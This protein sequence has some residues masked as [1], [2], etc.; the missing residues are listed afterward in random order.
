MIPRYIWKC[1]QVFKKYH[2][3]TWIS[4]LEIANFVHILAKK[5]AVISFRTH[6]SVFTWVIGYIYKFLIKLLYPKASKIIVNS[7]ENKYDI[8][9]YLH[10]PVEKVEVLY[11]TIDNKLIAQQRTESREERLNEV[12][13][14][15]MVF[16]T[17]GRLI[18][19][20]QHEKIVG[21]LH[22]IAQSWHLNWKYLIIWDGP[23]RW[24]LTSL[25][26]QYGLTDNV[27]FL[28]EQKNIFKYLDLTDYFLY[29]SA[30]E[31]FPNVLAEAKAMGIPIVTSDF[32]SGAKE[33]ILGQ[34]DK[35]LANN[36]SYPYRW[37]YWI[38]LDPLR[39]EEQLYNRYVTTLLHATP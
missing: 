8:A 24:Y 14:G 38:L 27:I 5:E 28:W 37:T 19:S 39:F 20:K 1:K 4:F 13:K 26:E 30:V 11:N 7:H 10:I 29:A 6:I 35:E 25:V 22:R 15:K 32:Q 3:H 12:C 16:V 17:T 23:Q 33:V 34:F 36:M 9:S 21:G 18:P 2:L 31:W